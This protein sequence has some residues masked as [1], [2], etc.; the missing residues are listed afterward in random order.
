MNS[1]LKFPVNEPSAYSTVMLDASLN[2]PDG[3]LLGNNNR[4][5]TVVNNAGGGEGKV[6]SF[7]NMDKFETATLT[8]SF[9]TG[10]VFPTTATTD[11]KNIY[12]LHAYLHLRGTG[13]DGF[14]I[15][16]AP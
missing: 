10:P 2:S 3:L 12:V 4:E 9:I 11:G 14:A 6:L 8:G 16:P 13:H 15:Q 1:I 5:L 7:T